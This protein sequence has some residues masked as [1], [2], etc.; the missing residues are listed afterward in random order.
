MKLLHIDG[1]SPPPELSW[2]HLGDPDDAARY[3]ALVEACREVDHLDPL[4]T[5][6]GIPSLEEVHARFAALPQANTLCA[7]WKEQMVAVVRISWWTEIGG[8][9]LYLHQGRVHP[10]W[11]GRGLGTAL[12]RW[13]E[14]RIRALAAQHPTN[15]KA[16]FGA[17]ASSTEVTAAELLMHEGY[18][19]FWI[20]AQMELTSF[21]RLPALAGPSPFPVRPVKPDQHRTIWEAVQRFWVGVATAVS[22]PDEADYQEFAAQVSSDPSLCF[23]AW[24]ADQPVGVVLCRVANGCGIIDE[25]SVDAAH[26]RQGLAQALLVQALAELQRRG[27]Q[28]IRLHTNAAN[29]NGARSLYEKLGFSTIKTYP[30]YR[31]PIK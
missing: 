21:E 11:R 30:R 26:R 6:E 2:R 15:G 29:P 10:D 20:G 18:Q 4:S 12:L 14:L 1:I 3:V 22:V 31:K 7:L 17:N 27:L 25:V 28:R 19:P 9:W 16:M 13:A 23:V 24:D 5:L 8:I